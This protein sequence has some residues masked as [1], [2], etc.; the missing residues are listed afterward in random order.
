ME[1]L[2]LDHIPKWNS[3]FGFQCFNF[4]DLFSRKKQ[5]LIVDTKNISKI[6]PKLYITIIRTEETT[7]AATIFKEYY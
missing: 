5:K 3:F 6:N 7:F 2:K 4:A 1:N